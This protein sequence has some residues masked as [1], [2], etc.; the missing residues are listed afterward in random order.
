MSN[1]IQLVEIDAWNGSAEVTLRF[2]THGYVTARTDTPPDTPYA[3]RLAESIK[4][5]RTSASEGSTRGE[6]ALSVGTL[7]LVNT[8]GALD[9]MIDYAYA[10][11]GIRVY[12]LAADA[13][14]SSATLLFS[15][16]L[17]QPRFDWTTDG[18]SVLQ[19]IVRDK[20]FD[21]IQPLQTSTYGG[22]NSL[23]AGVDGGAD[24][25]GKY[26]PLLYGYVQKIA[27]PCV[28]TARLIYQVSAG[29]I[30]D[31]SAVYDRGMPLTKGANYVSEADMQANAPA[32]SNFRV[33]P[34]GGMF[35]LGSTNAGQVLCDAVE[36]ATAASRYPG[37]VIT[38]ILTQAGLTGSDI[39]S[40][41]LTALDAAC[42]WEIGYWV[43]HENA[44]S[45]SEILDGIST[46]TNSW[47]ASNNA[48][49][50][51]A[52][53]LALPSGSPVLDLH[54]GNIISLTRRQSKDEDRGIP[55]W[56][57]VVGYSRYF[58][59]PVSDFAGAVTAATKEDWAQEYRTVS[60]SDSSVKTAY[61]A[62]T[63]VRID[64]LLRYSSDAQSL[65]DSQHALIKA[66]RDIL[67]CEAY[68]EGST[69]VDI[70][71]VVRITIPRF[72][73]NSGKLYTVIGVELD[74]RINRIA[75][76]LWG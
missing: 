46:S 50:I 67:V 14:L 27:P 26:K 70:G 59:T 43:T 47:W 30:A 28:N 76:T 2:S 22:T 33:W 53:V 66:K 60:V 35:R 9:Y 69:S 21:L 24:L 17:E 31:V 73:L 38:R 6:S 71:N 39:D 8:D 51:L 11:R 72:G 44:I 45:A 55:P 54:P 49:K 65:A 40:A 3:A 41:S 52:K 34:A 58:E 37:A 63:E 36:G 19:I 56:R 20:A 16:T 61:P 75:L 23:P 62:S 7:N 57:L 25:K 29:A 42:P 5:K 15:G 74:P 18:S 10:G 4:M 32:A 68:I 13:P 1:L 48:N 12:M 64:T